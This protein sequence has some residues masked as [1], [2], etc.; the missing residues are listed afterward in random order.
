MTLTD[1]SGSRTEN[2]TRAEASERSDLIST[3]SYEVVLDLTSTGPTFATTTTAL[4]AC[5]SIGAHTWIDLIAPTV[6]SVTLN[7][8]E[9]SLSQRSFTALESC[10][11]ICRK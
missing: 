11:R 3:T 7:G 4:F 2:I 10:S 6:E 1:A 8:T 5:T 9:L